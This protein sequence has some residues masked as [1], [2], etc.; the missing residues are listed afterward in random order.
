MAHQIWNGK[1]IYAGNAEE[2]WHGIGVYV[3]DRRLDSA[4]IL[5]EAGLDYDVYKL[6]LYMKTEFGGA[7][8]FEYLPSNKWAICRDAQE[9]DPEFQEDLRRPVQM[10]TVSKDY[11]VLHQREAFQIFD[12][13]AEEGLITYTAAGALANGARIW[14][15]AKLE[16]IPVE[17]T[18]VRELKGGVIDT[19]EAFWL[20]HLGHDGMTGINSNLS[21][22]RPVCANT[23]ALA[24]AEGMTSRARHTGDVMQNLRDAND[25]L[26][27]HH[28]RFGELMTVYREMAKRKMRQADVI[29]FFDRLYPVETPLD[30]LAGKVAS[31]SKAKRSAR[32]QN[33]IDD[34]IVRAAEGN[35]NGGGTLWDVFNGVTENFDHA[36]SDR[37]ANVASSWFGDRR[38]QRQKAFSLALD[39]LKAA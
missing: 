26:A 29:E 37:M 20:L 27:Q 4:A 32:R 25:L 2:V 31:A 16:N 30:G 21:G 13:L 28:T 38:I 34:M 12:P 14:I 19:V 17:D 11:Q 9:E 3:G 1:A 39:L 8:D 24:E 10:G 18:I 22:I 15:A 36:G 5:A 7:T 6:P 23:I 33:Q 35:G